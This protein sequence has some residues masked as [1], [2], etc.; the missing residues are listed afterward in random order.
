MSSILGPV[1]P[2]LTDFKIRELSAKDLDIEPEHAGEVTD[3]DN[4]IDPFAAIEALPDD[5]PFL[6]EVQELLGIHGGVIFA[7]PPGTSK[8]WYA[9]R[10]GV[11]L[12]DRD[13]DRIR[14]VQ[15]HPSYQ[16]EDFVEGFVANDDGS[17]FTLKPKHLLELCQTAIDHY[18]NPVVLV[19]D[20]LSRGEPG[21]IFGE[22]LTYVE[23]SKRGLS[24]HLASGRQCVIPDNLIFLA[25]MNPHDRGVE[26]VD[27]AFERRFAKIRMEP[28]LEQ[29]SIF[30][31]A[32]GMPSELQ[33]RVENFFRYVDRLARTNPYVA[34]GHTYFAGI[35][36]L[37]GLRSLWDHQLS[38]HFEK[39]FRLD[40]ER[41]SEIRAEW[42]KVMDVQSDEQEPDGIGQ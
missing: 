20:E 38:F 24:F 7:G 30:L 34:L 19:I 9:A 10:I 12:A 14:F 11:Q 41:L 28:K 21:R 37:N 3:G 2:R 33:Q 1:P 8:S 32:A 25:T 6:F 27:A 22:A 5:D 23:H 16:Y 18:P 42:D 40:P 29:V 15:F 13:P 39:F 35:G 17:G 36:D 31:S 4:S 26:E